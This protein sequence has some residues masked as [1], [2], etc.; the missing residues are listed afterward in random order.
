MEHFEQWH[1]KDKTKNVGPVKANIYVFKKTRLST[2]LPSKNF[3]DQNQHW[4]H[5]NNL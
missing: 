5:H 1:F 2:I 4:K 3:L